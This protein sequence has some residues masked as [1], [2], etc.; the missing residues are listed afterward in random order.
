VCAERTESTAG[1]Y[2]TL[3]DAA[4]RVRAW[5]ATGC[6]ETVMQALHLQ[7]DFFQ[8]NGSSFCLIS[9]HEH[10]VKH[11]SDNAANIERSLPIS[12]ISAV[13]CHV[14]VFNINNINRIDPPSLRAFITS[15]HVLV[16]LK[17]R[18]VRAM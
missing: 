15:R 1:E 9:S 16:T 2:K 17:I 14:R 6:K 3:V 7:L 18:N 5:L 13:S 10:G 8:E 4:A 12:M 11:E